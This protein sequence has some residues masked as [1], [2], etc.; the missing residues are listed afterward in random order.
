VLSIST[1]LKLRAWQQTGL[2][3]DH[4]L[5]DG[6]SILLQDWV[7]FVIQ[8]LLGLTSIRQ[9]L[10]GSCCTPLN[11]LGNLGIVELWAVSLKAFDDQ[12]LG[13]VKNFVFLHLD[14]EH[15]GMRDTNIVPLSEILLNTH[16]PRLSG[17]FVDKGGGKSP[18]RLFDQAFH[19]ET[20]QVNR[21]AIVVRCHSKTS[22]L[23][24]QSRNQ[25]SLLQFPR[26]VL[27]G[28]KFPDESV[29]I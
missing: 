9:P 5:T 27:L 25:I 14:Q 17:C 19:K 8:Q 1:K 12:E 4:L 29:E 2:C 20:L 3:L 18:W 16:S 6:H 24:A 15:S 10:W 7:I 11:H 13:R 21:A 23:F 28:R 26:G 22:D